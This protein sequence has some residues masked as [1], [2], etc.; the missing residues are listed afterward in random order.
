MTIFDPVALERRLGELNER[1]S[2]PGFWDNPKAAAV[3]SAEQSRAQRKLDAYRRLESEIGDLPTLLEMV[4][5]DG[6]LQ[7]EADATIEALKAEIAQLQE[8]ALF[9]GEYDGGDAI[10]TLSAGAG[11][12]DAQD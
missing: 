12:T 1:L 7:I 8:Q 2:A 9:S 3:V 4:S 11:G 10:V 5:E 6:D